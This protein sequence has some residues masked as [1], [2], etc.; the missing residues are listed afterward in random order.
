VVGGEERRLCK[1]QSSNERWEVG[2]RVRE[3]EELVDSCSLPHPPPS[4]ACYYSVPPPISTGQP[5]SSTTSI[6]FVLVDFASSSIRP[7]LAS[8][9]PPADSSFFPVAVRFSARQDEL[10]AAA[11]KPSRHVEDGEI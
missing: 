3:K 5:R 6:H 1:R 7:F 8:P 10:S 9:R 4:P 2:G 11:F